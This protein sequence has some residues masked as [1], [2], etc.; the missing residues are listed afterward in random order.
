MRIC[1]KLPIVLLLAGLVL[2]ACAQP[3]AVTPTPGSSVPAD[4]AGA[5]TAMPGA[6]DAGMEHGAMDHGTVADSSLP[7]D[8]QFIDSMIQHHVGAVEMAQM[9]LEQ[10]EHEELRALAS[11]II[12]A[13]QPE[14]EQMQDWRT[15]WYPELPSTQGMSMDMGEMAIA[16]DAGVPF[17][18][19]FL[20]AMISHHRGAIQMAQAA[21]TQAEHTEI[22]QLARAI[23]AAQE[24]EIAQMEE[25]LAD[26]YG[27]EAQAAPAS[28]SLAGTIWVANEAGD[29]LTAVDAA[30]NGVVATLTGIPGPHN[31]QVSPDG[32]TV[33]AVSGHD[34]LAVAVDAQTYTLL[35]A[36][37]VGSAPAHVI[38]SPDSTTVYVSNSGDNTVTVIDAVTFAVQATVPV[39]DYPHGLRPSPDGRWVAVANLRDNTVSLIDTSSLTVSAT[40]EVGAGPVQVAFAPDGAPLYVSLNGEDAV[41]AVDLE[42][43]T[44]TGKAAVGAGPVQVYV[45]PDG[46]SVVVANQGTEGAPSTTLSIVD[47]A[48]MREVDRVQTG[49]GAHGVA[50]EPS[51]RY[52]YVTN[53]YGN[54]L[55]VVDLSAR[56]TVATTPTGESPNG[57]SFSS[58]AP[59][60]PIA[61]EVALSLPVSAH[62]EETEDEPEGHDEHH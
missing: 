5:A 2:A 42:T 18:R 25:W 14:I 11:E 58:L 48:T 17:D 55:A 22:K 40:I 57:I 27:E 41:A 44:V 56:H 39:G 8:A 10:A 13:Q 53:L 43:Q 61:A 50:V 36:A 49:R 3:L 12:A 35:G 32:A 51:G 34:S 28:G 23:I 20:E 30:T 21:Q 16:E 1:W 19:R 46:A 54:D 31:V 7:F 37:P 59:A 60:V 26:W 38:V 45:T 47:A 6:E 29:S 4:D 15:A 9:A 24:G 52:A 62:E 33:W